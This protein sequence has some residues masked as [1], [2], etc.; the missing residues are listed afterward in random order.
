MSGGAPESKQLLE[1]FEAFTAASEQL[2]NRYEALQDQLGRLRNE[3][4][5]VIEAVPFALWVLGNEGE[6]RFTNRPQ[7]MAG[8]FQDGVPP[9]ELDSPT[10][11]RHFK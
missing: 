9:W 10:G 2:Q 3:L 11:L 5:T 6:L 8:C 1:A 7:G 4:E